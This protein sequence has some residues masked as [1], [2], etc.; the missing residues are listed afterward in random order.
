[1]SNSKFGSAFLEGIKISEIKQNNRADIFSIIDSMAKEVFKESGNKIKIEIVTEDEYE[2]QK[3]SY[4]LTG[5]ALAQMTIAGLGLGPFRNKVFH[6]NYPEKY[7]IN[8]LSN[9][10]K[11]DH[12]N[13]ILFVKNDKSTLSLTEFIFDPEGFPCRFKI[14]GNMVIS[15]DHIALE[16]NLSKLLAS[17]YAGD[18]FRTLLRD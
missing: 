2:K 10:I 12:L 4:G 9:E 16:N 15:N 7:Y 1:M 13:Y 11:P 5:Q 8:S 6:S 3:N 17:A 18:C 14:D